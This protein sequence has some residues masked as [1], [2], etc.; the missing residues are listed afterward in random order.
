[1]SRDAVDL[2]CGCGGL[3]LGL[4]KAGFDVV[5]GVDSWKAAIS[6]Y[7]KNFPAHDGHW[8]DLSDEN[9]TVEIVE[10]YAPFLVAGGPPC[11]D[12]SAAGVR[13]EGSRADLTVKF[14]SVIARSRPPAFIMENVPR[15]SLSTAY[16]TA[17]EIIRKAG[18]GVTKRVIDA[19]LCGVPQKRKRLF[20]I[21]MLGQPDGF[22][23]FY[24]D[25][26]SVAPKVTTVRE[27][28]GDEIDVDHYYRHPR[29]YGSRAIYSVDEPSATIRGVNRPRPSTYRKHKMDTADPCDANALTTYQRARIQTFP[30][31]YIWSDDVPRAAIEQMIGNAV[32]VDM[33]AYVAG[34][35]Y[36][37]AEQVMPQEQEYPYL[38]QK[39]E[40]PEEQFEYRIAAE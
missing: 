1:M 11:Q 28:M 16:K 19:S 17:E 35:L 26:D 10:S 12:F 33:A 31:S 34:V 4:A 6:V 37:F 30:K 23:D 40:Q 25:F 18:Y 36:R 5:A 20:M 7:R 38:D 2:F 8:F 32:P 3:T 13:V 15:A 14:A 22:L 9:G 29:T 27:Y 24:F 39:P 21:G